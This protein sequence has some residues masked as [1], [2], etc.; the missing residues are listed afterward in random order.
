M[1]LTDSLPPLLMGIFGLMTLRNSRQFPVQPS[2]SD[3]GIIQ[4]SSKDRQLPIML[5]IEIVISL[6][7]STVGSIP[8]RF[9]LRTCIHTNFDTFIFEFHRFKAFS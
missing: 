8:P 6:V 5:L 2:S 9:C 7:F 4:L 1:T 3:N